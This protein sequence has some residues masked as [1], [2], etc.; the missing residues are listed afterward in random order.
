MGVHGV[1]LDILFSPVPY[2]LTRSDHMLS[3]MLSM[4][5]GCTV[6]FEEHLHY[7]SNRG[8]VDKISKRVVRS[9]IC[10]MGYGD[11]KEPLTT[12]FRG[13]RICFSGP[14]S[15]LWNGA[16]DCPKPRTAETKTGP[17]L[18]VLKSHKQ[19]KFPY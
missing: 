10:S 1:A 6:R 11:R 5:D 3:L 18:G 7:L 17:F 4:F 9:E 15:F 14:S 2:F 13:V 16:P 8:I 12:R 19:G